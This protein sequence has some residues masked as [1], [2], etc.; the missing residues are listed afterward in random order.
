MSL[1]QAASQKLPGA[2]NEEGKLLTDGFLDACQLIVPV[3]GAQGDSQV[4][5]AA[6]STA[7]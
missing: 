5:A 3:I 2:R 1:F 7:V 6:G 4:A